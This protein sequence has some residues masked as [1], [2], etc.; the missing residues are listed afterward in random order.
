MIIFVQ[1]L[2]VLSSMSANCSPS[3]SLGNRNYKFALINID[4]PVMSQTELSD[5]LV[6]FP[7]TSPRLCVDV[8]IISVARRGNSELTV[9]RKGI[10][11]GVLASNLTALQPFM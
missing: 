8:H 7:Y 5:P 11:P 3:S 10:A 9:V 6:H 2:H 4:T 1:L